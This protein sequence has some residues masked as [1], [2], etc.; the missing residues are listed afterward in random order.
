MQPEFPRWCLKPPSI[1][2]GVIGTVERNGFLFESGPQSFLGTPPTLDL[3]RELKLEAELIEADPNAPRYV[4]VKGRLQ[5]IPMSPI[6]L[7]TSVLAERRIA[8]SRA[9]RAAAPDSSLSRT[10]NR[11]RTSC[12]ENSGMKFSNISW[13]RLCRASMPAIPETLSLRAAFPSLDEWEREYG[14]VLRGAMNSRKQQPGARPGLCTFRGGLRTLLQ[15]LESDLADGLV[16]GA[17]VEAIERAEPIPDLPCDSPRAS[18][19]ESI[20]VRAI[21]MAAPAYI[22]GNLLAGI[23]QRA[24]DGLRGVIY[25]PVAVIAA[26]YKQSTNWEQTRRVR[27]ADSAQ[28]W[29]AYAGH[30]VEFFAVSGPRAGWFRDRDKFRR[31]RHRYRNCI[32]R[33]ERDSGARRGRARRVCWRS[34]GRPSR[35]R[36]GAIRRR[37]LNII[38]GTRTY[39]RMCA[40]LWRTCRGFIWREITSADLP[41]GIASSRA[42]GL[43][44]VFAGFLQGAVAST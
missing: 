20:A 33:A 42:I 2:G 36:S 6:A 35:E 44:K 31:W 27:R 9:D 10:K 15:A 4:Y 17:R 41:L 24:A 38:L 30:G 40:G 12:A 23:S 34:A 16:E 28:G 1:R 13:R 8:V 7:F 29:T 5:A 3:I 39:W 11:W 32:A 43:R 25:A 26:G 18:Q 37:C 14:S 19:H 21:V 22:A